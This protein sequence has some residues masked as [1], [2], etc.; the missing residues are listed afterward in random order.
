[1]TD[2]RAKQLLNLL[3]EYVR[4]YKADDPGILGNTV[5][6]TIDDLASTLPGGSA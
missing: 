2:E 6:E 5:E 1:M 3:R 4:D